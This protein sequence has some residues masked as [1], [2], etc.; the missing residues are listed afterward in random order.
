M[1]KKYSDTFGKITGIILVIGSM[2]LFYLVMQLAHLPSLPTVWI[3]GWIIACGFGLGIFLISGLKRRYSLRVLLTTLI[4]MIPWSLI[5]LIP[6]P[7]NVQIPLAVLIAFAGIMVYYHRK[8]RSSKPETIQVL[9]K[10]LGTMLVAFSFLLFYFDIYLG[11]ERGVFIAW[12]V[13]LPI[14][15]LFIIG[16]SLVVR[17][18]P[19]RIVETWVGY[20]LLTLLP[21]I[22]IL[23]IV[24]QIVSL[25]ILGMLLTL[26]LLWYRKK[27]KSS[28]VHGQ[29]ENSE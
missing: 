15:L 2:L 8:M 12:I 24:W 9:R 21:W 10:T 1:A 19:R 26:I 18:G 27:W 16:C 22:A 13:T 23:P 3:L 14:A 25:T 28:V 20:V 11:I 6:L 17:A 5:L 29:T 7:D 4:I